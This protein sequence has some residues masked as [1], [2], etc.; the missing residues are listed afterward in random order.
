MG[1]A[2]NISIR[3]RTNVKRHTNQ[4]SA[5]A[6]IRSESKNIKIHYQYELMIVF[7]S[8]GL[9]QHQNRNVKLNYSVKLYY[10]VLQVSSVCTVKTAL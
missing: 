6:V 7:T 10:L 1:K 3:D 8:T 5:Y 2:S 4:K 9:I